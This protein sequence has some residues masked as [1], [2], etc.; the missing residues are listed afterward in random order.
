VASPSEKIPALDGLRGISIGLV[1]LAHLSGTRD[2][3]TGQRLPDLDSLGNLGVRIFFVISGYLIT[4]LLLQERA[5]TGRISLL[6]FYLRRGVRIFPAAY[7]YMGV[8]F[9]M[10]AFG[11]VLLAPGDR[12]HA[13][14][15][16]V[17]YHHLRSWFVS[18]LW[19]LSVEEQ[20]YLLWPATLLLLGT[21]RGLHLALA[22]VLTA[23]L[24]RVALWVYWPQRRIEIGEA[25]TT[26]GDAIASGCLLAGM[27]E[28]LGRSPRYLRLVSSR[29]FALL[30][31]LV[32]VLNGFQQYPVIDFLVGETIMNL[33]IALTIDRCVRVSDD[34]VRRLLDSRL[35]SG[36]GVLSYSLYLWQEPF[37]NRFSRAEVTWFPVN[38]M[39]T[40]AAAVASHYLVERP[41]L[42]LRQRLR[43]A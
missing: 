2:L 20:F 11:L 10:A 1:L 42:R 22:L 36:M 37:L 4:L 5:A 31:I 3:A 35:L 23:P 41:L 27:R 34:W 19:S 21:R 26:I 25:F 43:R 30:P 15:Y 12:L 17:N 38:L 33:A 9:S 18:H 40:F 13:L 7:L 32:F 14:T 39:L 6:R 24:I 29:W 28:R 16:T 8:M